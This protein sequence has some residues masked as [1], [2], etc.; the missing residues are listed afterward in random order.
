MGLWR[1]KAVILG[2]NIRVGV[3]APLVLVVC[4]IYLGCVQTKRNLELLE[5]Q[6]GQTDQL[7]IL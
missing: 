1:K 3:R 2:K 4:T 7:L 5:N 6:V